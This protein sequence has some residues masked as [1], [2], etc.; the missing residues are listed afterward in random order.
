[1]ASK[2]YILQD[3]II[4]VGGEGRN[5]CLYDV[6]TK[7]EMGQWAAHTSRI[8]C[9]CTLPGMA[10][11]ELWL[12]SASS[13]GII[14]IWSLEVRSSRLLVLLTTTCISKV[15]YCNSQKTTQ[16]GTLEVN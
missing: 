9:L 6:S 8:K 7:M 15:N 14:K 10:A 5:I 1:M 16:L 2:V 3:D 4:A 13:D 12:V 11:E